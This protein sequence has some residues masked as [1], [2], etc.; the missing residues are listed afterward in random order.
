MLGGGHCHTEDAVDGS[1]AAVEG[2]LAYDDEVLEGGAGEDSLTGK[3]AECDGEV[4][5]RAF[6]F[7][8]G[9]GEVHEGLGFR[10]FV[11]GID[12]CAADALGA[13]LYGGVGEA[14]DQGLVESA[15]GYVDLDLANYALDT[16]EGDTMQ[17]C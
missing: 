10:V 7:D 9:G 13:F 5:G 2:E 11:A 8:V 12:D 17:S 6:L 4:E 3:D 1:D 16:F 14:D 15:A